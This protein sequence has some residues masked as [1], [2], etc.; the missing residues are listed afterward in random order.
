MYVLFE[1]ILSLQTWASLTTPND[2]QASGQYNNKY[3]HM[4]TH[5]H[6]YTHIH[7][8]THVHTYT[9]KHTCIRFQVDPQFFKSTLKFT[10][11]PQ[12]W[13][14]YTMALRIL[15]HKHTH[16]HTHTHTYAP[17]P[18]PDWAPFDTNQSR[19]LNVCC[20]MFLAEVSQSVRSNS[21]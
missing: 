15:T 20:S 9:H 4:H 16:T 7:T 17:S 8:H 5:T 1:S 2:R 14:G 21:G 6:M 12:L 11:I 3:T 19:S 13:M 18:R 10:F